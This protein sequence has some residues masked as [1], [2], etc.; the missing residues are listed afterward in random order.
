MINL[1]RG[2]FQQHPYHLVSPSAWPVFTSFSLGILAGTGGISMHYFHNSY[3]VLYMAT[4]IVIMTMV[5]WFRDIITEG[6]FLGDHTIA[7]QRGLTLGFILFVVSEALFFLSV[8]WAYFHSSLTPSCELGCTWPPAGVDPVNPFEL[9]LLNTIILLSSGSTITWAH[10]S[11]IG[12]NRKGAILG[13]FA[14]VILALIFTGFQ[15]VEYYQSSFTLSDGVFG[16][17]FFFATGFHGLHVIIGALFIAIGLW[18]IFA[19]QLTN[20]HHVGFE[21]SILY[22]HF[23]DV[24]WL[25]L[26]VSIYYWGS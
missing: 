9:P 8:F 19:Y 24:V 16:S 18:R 14:T 1:I 17:T 5:L 4:V 12:G 26:Y 20:H 15:A 23:V 22:W 3:I 7:V 10:H 2:N 11:L 21:S 6:T 13:T 25:I